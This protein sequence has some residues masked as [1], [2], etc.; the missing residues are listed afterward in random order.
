MRLR[1]RIVWLQ[2]RE[3]CDEFVDKHIADKGL[4]VVVLVSRIAQALRGEHRTSD[5]R[6]CI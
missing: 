3:D 4:V 6:V 2:A 5:E 1:S